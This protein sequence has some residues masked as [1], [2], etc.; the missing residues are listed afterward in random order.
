M[1][2]DTVSASLIFCSPDVIAM[3]DFQFSCANPF[4]KYWFP[5]LKVMGTLQYVFLKYVVKYF[6]KKYANS[7]GI[8][9]ALKTSSRNS[10]GLCKERSHFLLAI[11]AKSKPF[12]WLNL[13]PLFMHRTDAVV[14]SSLSVRIT[15]RTP[16]LK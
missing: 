11:R 3:N 9:S 6:Q 5:C 13:V 14:L 12:K 1:D 15:V 16:I 10:R 8:N 4:E 2:N 7:S